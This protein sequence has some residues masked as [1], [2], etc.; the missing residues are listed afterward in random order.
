[1]TACHILNGVPDKKTKVTPYE[2]WKKRKSNLF[3][4]RVLGCQSI[5]RLP[6]PKIK[7][8]GEKSIEC[9][10]LGYANHSKAYRFIII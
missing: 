10:F 9:T 4:L 2:L 6:K 7:K 3:Y 1:M 8:L 5:V